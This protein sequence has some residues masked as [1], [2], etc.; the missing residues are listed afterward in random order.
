MS[1]GRCLDTRLIGRGGRLTSLDASFCPMFFCVLKNIVKNI[2]VDVFLKNT[3]KHRIVKEKARC[4][5]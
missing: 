2:D 3:S 5:T 1:E 4:F